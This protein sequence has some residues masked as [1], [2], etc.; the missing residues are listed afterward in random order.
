MSDPGSTPIEFHAVSLHV[1][2]PCFAIALTEDGTLRYHYEVD[3]DSAP[4]H[5]P[6]DIDVAVDDERW[7]ELAA[8]LDRIDV[9]SWRP[10]YGRCETPA[11]GQSWCLGITWGQRAVRS[12]GANAYPGSAGSHEPSDAFLDWCRA[13]RAVVGGRPFA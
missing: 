1:D 3:G 2:G 7:A 11:R 12:R 13:V 4:G 6:I 10:A 9:W 5:G 8:E